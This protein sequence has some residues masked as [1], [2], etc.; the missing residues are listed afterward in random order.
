MDKKNLCKVSNEDIEV[1]KS[2][3]KNIKV[4]K[5]SALSQSNV[6]Q[7]FETI[8]EMMVKVTISKDG[9]CAKKDIGMT[10]G[11]DNM[12]APSVRRKKCAC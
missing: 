12:K 11:K 10:V 9:T 2:N 6:N 3:L 1:L 5:T 7:V 8:T 4:I